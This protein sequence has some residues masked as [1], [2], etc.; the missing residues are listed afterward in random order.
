M[1]HAMKMLARMLLLSASLGA[2]QGALAHH[3]FAMFDKTKFVTIAGTVLKIEWANPHAYLQVQVPG[4]NGTST[5]Y[6]IECSSPNELSRWGWKYN[7]VKVGD[8][9]SAGIYPLRNGQPGGLLFSVT[10]ANGTVFK[11]N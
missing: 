2:G 1:K 7:S 3:S 6:A 8:H 11:G 5:L 10:L 4:S 9:I